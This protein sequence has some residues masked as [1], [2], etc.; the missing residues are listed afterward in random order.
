[1]QYR[2]GLKNK[3]KD[4]LALRDDVKDFKALITTAYLIDNRLYKRC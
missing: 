3:I 4:E 2:R 1:M